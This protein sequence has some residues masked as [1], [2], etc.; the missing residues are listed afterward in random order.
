MMMVIHVR[1]EWE[2]VGNTD[3]VKDTS[4]VEWAETKNDEEGRISAVID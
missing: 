3:I 2:T 4:W 1:N